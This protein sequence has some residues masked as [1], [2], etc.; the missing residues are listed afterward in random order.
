MALFFPHALPVNEWWHSLPASV[1]PIHSQPTHAA[2]ALE[3]PRQDFPSQQQ[4]PEL[5]DKLAWQ[6][7][8]LSAFSHS[9]PCTRKER[10]KRGNICIKLQGAIGLSLCFRAISA[11]SWVQVPA[12]SF[13]LS[14]AGNTSPTRTTYSP[15]P[16]PRFL[17]FL[18]H[19][20]HLEI[21]GQDGQDETTKKRDQVCLWWVIAGVSDCQDTFWDQVSLRRLATTATTN[22]AK[23]VTFCQ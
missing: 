5:E 7:E 23:P 8:H 12:P 16:R 21:L 15:P 10:T 11:G 13:S 22:P 19:R 3:H 1:H 2:P 6:R 17:K 4:R 9:I 18:Q 20:H 14:R